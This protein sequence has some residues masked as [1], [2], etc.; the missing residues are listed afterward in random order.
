MLYVTKIDWS[1]I[2]TAL[3]VY[4]HDKFKS[5]VLD[6]H[7]NME[8]G[9][10]EIINCHF[11]DP[12]AIKLYLFGL[13]ARIEIARALIGPTPDDKAWNIIATFSELRNIYAHSPTYKTAEGEKRIKAKVTEVWEKI[14]VVNPGLGPNFP[15]PPREDIVQRA[16]VVV[17][18]FF[19]EI[20]A[21]LDS[22]K[23]QGQA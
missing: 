8:A 1:K 15:N 19:R 7:I 4:R 14:L 12:G 6:F 9:V 10:N 22:A 18:R 13:K 17:D 11:R 3:T 23:E 16:E 2:E 21:H 20:N 5:A